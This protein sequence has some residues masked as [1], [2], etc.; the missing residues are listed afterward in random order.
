MK[1]TLLSTVLTRLL[2]DYV[3]IRAINR[4]AGGCGLAYYKHKDITP[5]QIDLELLNWW[6]LSLML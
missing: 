1:L 3:L 6:S 4:A 5:V 2:C